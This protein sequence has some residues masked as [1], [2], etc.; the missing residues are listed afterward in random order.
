M[1]GRV[2]EEEA[3]GLRGQP[4]HVVCPVVAQPGSLAQPAGQVGRQVA[5]QV[6]EQA[7]QA[8]EH[9]LQQLWLTVGAWVPHQ[10]RHVSSATSAAP[11]QQHH[12]EVQR[13]LCGPQRTEEAVSAGQGSL[14][15][16][17]TS[18][19]MRHPIHAMW[20]CF[21]CTCCREQ[22]ATRCLQRKAP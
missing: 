17:A 7:R 14:S 21:R 12:T 18:P 13:R 4:P 8:P 22:R 20:K 5:H 3:D 6:P 16:K 11:H 19:Q 1:P 9:V 15:R 2:A 10:H